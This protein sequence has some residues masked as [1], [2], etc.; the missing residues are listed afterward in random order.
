VNSGVA[1]LSSLSSIGTITTGT[2]N[3][4]VIGL[5]YGGTGQATAAAA[6]G[7]SGLNIDEMTT[8]TSAGDTNYTILNT[9]R[10]VAIGTNALTAART[11]TLPAASR[12]DG[13]ANGLHR[14]QGRGHHIYQHADD[15]PCRIGHDQ[16]HHDLRPQRGLCRRMSG[17]RQF[18][19]LDRRDGARE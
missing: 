10:F 9:D 6:R 17:F 4:T 13:R 5:T 15:S 14:R 19:R 3:G 11:W 2:W 7:S 16:R 18:Q 12:A 8:P 1:T